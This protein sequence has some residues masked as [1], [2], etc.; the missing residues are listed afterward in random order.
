LV[1]AS[2]LLAPDPPSNAAAGMMA[3]W[4]H[5]AARWAFVALGAGI[6][7]VAGLVNR[8]APSKRRRIRRTI[9]PFLIYLVLWAISATF[10]AGHAQDWADRVHAG[11]ELFEVYAVIN[12]TGLA[13]FD[14]ILP[15][16]G[17]DAAIIVADLIIGGGYILGTIAVLRSNGMDLGSVVATSAIVSGVLAL[18]LQATLGN[19]LGGVALQLDHSIHAGD[20]I[21]LPDGT[22]GKVR[23]VH[24]RHTVV[25]TR[26]W[27]TLL[28]PNSSLLA[29]N[30]M[31]LG[32]RAGMPVQHRMWVYFNVDF[33]YS[34]SHVIAVVQDALR[35]TPIERVAGD[36]PPNVICYDFAKDGRDS[37]AYYAVR[38][39]LTDL[40]VD[41]PTSSVV[42][43]HVYTALR[44]ANI[45]LARPSRTVLFAP[46]DSHDVEGRA[47]R[48]RAERAKILAGVE[49]FAPLT[50]AE[51]AKVADH[52]VYAPFAKGETI[53]RQ[54][55]VAHW[56]YIL[57]GGQAEICSKA[58]DG[59]KARHVA[60]LN[61]PAVFGEMGLFTGAP[62]TADVIA[63]TDVECFR[64]DKLGFEEIIHERPEVASALAKTMAKRRIELGAALDGV[65]V[66]SRRG[67]ELGES[68]QILGRIRSFFGLERGPE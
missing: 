40:A 22:Q 3:L 25:E 8:F 36:P 4:E 21:Q 46:D 27:D 49:L 37:F 18:S 13:V 47:A 9:I 34:P 43:E 52:L 55:A 29:S 66:E 10:A 30:I 19:I 56:L 60:T 51:R 42:R 16:L 6:V 39:W 63:V 24:W 7:V 1:L 62:R 32:K 12:L 23:E 38:Y 17:I 50:E 33:R 28:V 2:F 54:G 61:A 20:W 31:I 58:G 53:T 64:L 57:V 5:I 44:R 35:A 14:L 67:R 11:A 68:D 26:N 15:A 59:E 45:P 41:D 65:P 48:H